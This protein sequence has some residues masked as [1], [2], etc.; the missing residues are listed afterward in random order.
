[1]TKP[2]YKIGDRVRKRS[3]GPV[4]EVQ[5]VYLT[6]EKNGGYMVSCKL[7]EPRTGGM[8]LE[9][10][11]GQYYETYLIR[12]PPMEEASK[13]DVSEDSEGREKRP[14]VPPKE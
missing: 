1:M 14:S 5:A 9:G 11:P 13:D 7:A 8:S 2:Q 12:V 10:G 3:G 4:L 6:R